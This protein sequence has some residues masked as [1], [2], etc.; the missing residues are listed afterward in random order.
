MKIYPGDSARCPNCGLSPTFS[1]AEAVPVREISRSTA[2]L[3]AFFFGLLGVH[4]FYMGRPGSG[5]AYIVALLLGAALTSVG[6]GYFILFV[7][8]VVSVVESI[9]LFCMSDQNFRPKYCY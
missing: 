7:A 8:A 9:V 6:I 5:F 4:R 3:L 1:G 2:A